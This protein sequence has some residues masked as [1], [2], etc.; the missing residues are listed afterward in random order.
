MPF[1]VIAGALILYVLGNQS[2]F[3][4]LSAARKKFWKVDLSTPATPVT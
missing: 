1:C 3:Q 4:L 2:F